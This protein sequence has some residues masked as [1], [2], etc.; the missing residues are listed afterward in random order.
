MTTE[1]AA[2]RMSEALT[3]LVDAGKMPYMGA[4]GAICATP[5]N[6]PERMAALDHF[7][8]VTGDTPKLVEPRI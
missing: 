4:V 8:P 5:A 7:K 2:A 1:E 6:S 3:V